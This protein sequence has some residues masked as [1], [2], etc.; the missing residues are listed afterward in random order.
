MSVLIETLASM[1]T[2]S[3]RVLIVSGPQPG[4]TFAAQTEA[5]RAAGATF[6]GD[7]REWYLFLDPTPP[8][9]FAETL[10]ALYAIAARYG[11]T[12]TVQSPA[13]WRPVQAQE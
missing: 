12:V 5:L 10:T 6:D 2:E 3:F 4:E 7:S 11:A 9:R 8:D 13:H 1:S